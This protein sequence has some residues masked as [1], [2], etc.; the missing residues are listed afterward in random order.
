MRKS[1][2]GWVLS[3]A[4]LLPGVG[5]AQVYVRPTPYPQVTA[6]NA[7]WQLRG[8]PVF[9][10]GAFY[11][12][13]GPTVFFDGNVMMRTDTFEGVPVYEDA[14][15][16]P[17]SVVYIPIGG[18]V[19]RPYERRRE[20]ELAGTVGSRT[21]S[22]PI[23]RD[24]EV[25]VAAAP[26]GFT[27]IITPPVDLFFP[28]VIPE[29]ARPIAPI[30]AITALLQ[31]SIPP[32]APSPPVRRANANSS[33]ILQVWV[34]FD[35]ARWYSAGSAVSYAP[36]RFAQVGEYRGFPVYRDKNGRADEIYIPSVVGGP[37]APYR[38]R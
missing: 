34:P 27:G 37:V 22:F 2:L 30:G 32:S 26:L 11:Y 21:P 7:L 4:V 14:T 28:V 38:K 3:I 24:G 8:D 10:A 12:P 20:G 23:Q 19:V 35:G 31:A 33:T 13:T 5:T 15:Q 17:Y 9:H 36:D 6:A 1:T 29:A 25:S 16:T 18:N